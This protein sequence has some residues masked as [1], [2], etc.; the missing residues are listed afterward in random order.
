MN[1]LMFASFDCWVEWK[2][3]TNLKSTPP[4]QKKIKIANGE[5]VEEMEAWY[6]LMR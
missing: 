5:R 4:N 2:H 3:I 1:E 6:D